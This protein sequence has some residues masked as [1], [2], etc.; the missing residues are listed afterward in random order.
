MQRDDDKE[1]GDGEH[2]DG[3]GIAV[4]PFNPLPAL[5]WLLL[6]A[7]IVVEAVL[8]AGGQ[9]LI[10][11]S[12]ALGWRLEAITRYGFS[13]AVQSVMLEN[14]HFAGAYLLRYATFSFIHTGPMHAFFVVVLL[15][16]LGKYVGDAFGALRLLAVLAPA[17]LG[18][19]VIFGLIIGEGERAWLVGGM[20]MVFALV[21]AA[22]WWR[23]QRP[24]ESGEDD[25][26][27][28][29]AVWLIGGVMLLRAVIGV[30]I[31]PGHAWIA[32]LGAFGLGLALAAVIGP[33]G[34]AMIRARL[35]AR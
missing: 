3:A 19:A 17:T 20:P 32:D 28:R 8:W 21:G 13:G 26:R 15:A 16:A 30:T 14:R 6:L 35:R 25:A 18:G 31:E 22:S 27:R 10:G 23:W 4:S 12:Q 24:A 11:G 7:I 9:G 34:W 2:G 5:L 29:R 1:H 33:G